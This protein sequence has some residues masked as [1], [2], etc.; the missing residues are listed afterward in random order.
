MTKITHSVRFF[1]KNEQEGGQFLDSPS[2]LFFFPCSMVLPSRFVIPH[3]ATSG[4]F[5]GT[6][7]YLQNAQIPFCIPFSFSKL[8]VVLLI[9]L[10]SLWQGTAI[11]QGCNIAYTIRANFFFRISLNSFLSIIGI[12]ISPII[13]T[14]PR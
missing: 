9:P 5:C 14:P 10:E 3:S 4:R 6:N 13:T 12:L 8:S 7:T 2:H 11:M 1:L